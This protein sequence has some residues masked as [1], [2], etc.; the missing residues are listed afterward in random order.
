MEVDEP[1]MKE[2]IV[3][4]DREANVYS[5]VPS[6]IRTSLMSQTHSMK[7]KMNNFMSKYSRGH[8]RSGSVAMKAI[9]EMPVRGGKRAGSAHDLMSHHGQVRVAKDFSTPAEA[10]PTEEVLT[11]EEVDE[12]DFEA[13]DGG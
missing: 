11:P 10:A 7:F 9:N 6:S 4:V 1:L 13:Q 5:T 2:W 12:A 8:R 3:R